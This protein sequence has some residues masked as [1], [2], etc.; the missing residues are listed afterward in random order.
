MAGPYGVSTSCSCKSSYLDT[1]V[2]FSAKQLYSDG[3]SIRVWTFLVRNARSLQRHDDFLL[4]WWWGL[5]GT[6]RTIH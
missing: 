3:H 4:C 2:G 1:F 6:M 5:Y